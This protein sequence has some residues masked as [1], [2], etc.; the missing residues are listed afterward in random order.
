MARKLARSSRSRGDA[1]AGRRPRSRGGRHLCRVLAHL[2]RRE[3]E[4]ECLDLPNEVLDLAEG[5][6]PDAPDL[7]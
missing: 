4:P 1:V 6:P 3:M 7:E 2:E 5:E